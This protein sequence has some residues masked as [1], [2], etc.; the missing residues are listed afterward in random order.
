M[1]I[2]REYYKTLQG[3]E[4]ARAKE[5][6]S[7]TGIVKQRAEKAYD[8]TMDKKEAFG[9]LGYRAAGVDQKTLEFVKKFA[10]HVE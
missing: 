8:W 1:Q 3:K 2:V 7:W 9:N 4:L 10:V 6:A 5:V